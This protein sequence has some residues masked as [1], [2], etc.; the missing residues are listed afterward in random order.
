ML[1]GLAGC[2]MWRR[3][4]KEMTNVIFSRASEGAQLRRRVKPLL[5]T[6]FDTFWREIRGRR[7]EYSFC[8]A[9]WLAARCGTG[10]TGEKTDKCFF[11]VWEKSLGPF[12]GLI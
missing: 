8:V 3:G 9:G 2:K 10:G 4:G 6:D 1:C 11:L 12:S 5:G 7:K